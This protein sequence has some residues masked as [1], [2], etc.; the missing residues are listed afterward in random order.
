MLHINVI[1]C[2]LGFYHVSIDI[3]SL[4]ITCI[5]VYT[6]ASGSVNRMDM[7]EVKHR[8]SSQGS[9]RLGGP[10]FHKILIKCSDMV[11]IISHNILAI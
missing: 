8:V 3:I 6:R 7:S 10:I 5:K 9:Q 4:E 11:K 2:V 1:H